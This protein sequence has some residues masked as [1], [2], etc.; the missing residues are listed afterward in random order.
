MC[1]KW[2]FFVHPT[3][4]KI[5]TREDEIASHKAE[6]ELENVMAL[7]TMEDDADGEDTKMEDVEQE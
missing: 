2:L 6:Y 4:K 7:Q 1:E 5:M 3:G